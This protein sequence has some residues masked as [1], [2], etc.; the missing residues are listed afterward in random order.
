MNPGERRPDT[1]EDNLMVVLK[2]APERVLRRCSNIY[3]DGED[4]P[5]T[6]EE[7]ADIEL[8]NNSFGS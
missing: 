3:I 1:P 6:E 2:G 5:L 7:R 4:M 8:A